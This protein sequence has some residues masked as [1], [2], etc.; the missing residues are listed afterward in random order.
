MIWLY[1]SA[2]L[3]AVT[4]FLHSFLGE[5]RLIVPLLAIDAPITQRFLAR[6]VIRFAWHLTT[7][8]ILLCAALVIWPGVPEGLVLTTGLLWL[9]AGLFDAVYTHGQHIGWPP[10]AAA[11]LFAIM[12]VW[13]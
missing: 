5:R 8:L 10:I 7:V 3:M 1:L 2:I 12:G 11:G 4:G 6:K 13:L 9:A